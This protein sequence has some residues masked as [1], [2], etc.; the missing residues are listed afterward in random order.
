MK[1]NISQL[2]RFLVG[3]LFVFSGFVKAVD[4]LGTAIKL[5][6]YYIAWSEN[7]SDLFLHL[8]MFSLPVAYF[9]VSAEVLLGVFLLFNYKRDKTLKA[10]LIVILFF[11]VLTCYTALTGQP[12]DCGCFGDFMV[13][14]PWSSFIKDLVLLGMIV[15]MLKHKKYIIPEFKGSI[16]NVMMAFSSV[17]IFGFSYYNLVHLPVIDFRPY[18]IGNDITELVLGS[19]AVFKY[20]LSS[21]TDSNKTILVKDLEAGVFDDY[22]WKGQVEVVAAIPPK[23]LE[24]RIDNDS[25]ENITKE[26]MTG[27]SA[28]LVIRKLKYLNSETGARLREIEQ[29]L[30]GLD[31][32]VYVMSGATKATFMEESSFKKFTSPFSTV[33][34]DISKA[35]IRANLGLVLFDNGIVVGKWAL[36]DI[37]MDKLALLV[38]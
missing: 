29:L 26:A 34:E 2:F 22:N 31:V 13:I 19:P 17:G 37:P 7:I 36:D 25:G 20:E 6:K 24:F 1:G 30:Q 12:T 16:G 18:K 38:L 10:L 5:D 32:K 9:V 27:N 33:D 3:G 4:P 15:F 8:T 23:I 14:S 11:T 28:F 21:K 35:M